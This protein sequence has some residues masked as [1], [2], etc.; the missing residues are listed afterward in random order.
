MPTLLDIAGCTIPDGVT[1]HSLLPLMRDNSDDA[2]PWRQHV[3]GNCG[4][5]YSSFDGRWRYQW[6]GVTG[7]ELLFD[8]CEDRLDLDDRSDDPAMQAVKQGLRDALATWMQQHDDIH[9]DEHGAIETV[10]VET[11]G[12]DTSP[13]GF[14]S[15]PWNNRGWR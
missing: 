8:Q 12:G 10:P 14:K 5:L 1:G 6:D 13:F 11:V 15:G 7:E 3:F 4:Q 9:C 2:A